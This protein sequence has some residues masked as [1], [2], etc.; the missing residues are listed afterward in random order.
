[1]TAEAPGDRMLH[2]E[3]LS[4]E[5]LTRR[6]A[7]RVVD[8]LSLTVERGQAVGL[9]G[10]SGS[11]KSMTALATVRLLPP[12][13]RIVGGSVWLAGVD[14]LELSEGEL[15]H[16]RGGRVGLVFQN[17][18]AALN[19]LMRVGSQIARVAQLHAGL[20]PR[21][22][23][24]RAE[25]LLERVGIAETSRVSRSYPHQLSGGMAQRVLIA[26]VLAGRPQLLIADE[27]TTGL[28]ATTE[29]QILDLLQE[30]RR[31]FQL[32]VLLITHDLALVAENCDRVVVM[33]AGHAV[34][35]GTARRLFHHPLH[36]YTQGLLASMP[37]PDS[38]AMPEVAL[39]GRAPD[40]L[41]APREGCRFI[42]RC[43][44]RMER[45]AEPI[46]DHV[47]EVEPGHTVMCRLYD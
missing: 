47:A 3:R 22:A 43:A 1:M 44:R 24:G 32:S 31:D 27:P 2:I 35:A 13:A 45:C 33:H 12:V 40:P 8:R 16:I 20:E 30:L 26:A 6:G 37:R 29:V 46:H 7:A 15:Q 21:A 28:D 9:V 11:G 18:R 38:P 25:E 14:L 42:E 34:E 41:T 4:V 36:P 39:T 19:P 23:A 5:L 10:E 17:A